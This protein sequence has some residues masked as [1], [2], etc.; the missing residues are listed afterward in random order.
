MERQ[1]VS[2]LTPCTRRRGCAFALVLALAL[3]PSTGVI[4]Q[5][6][7]PLV[8]AATRDPHR[9]ATDIGLDKSRKGPEVLAF[10]GIRPGWRVIDLMQG[11]GYYTRLFIAAAGPQGKAYAWSPDEFVASKKELYGD[12]L[13]AM[14][15]EY[16]DR[17]T[18]L[19]TPFE[20][21]APPANLD[22]VF[23]SQNY[24][25]LLVP[26]RAP[27]T[28]DRLNRQIFAALKPGGVYLIIDHV[29]KPGDITAPNR[30]HRIDPAVLRAQVEA[31]G[32]VFDGESDALRNPS[33]D[34]DKMVMDPS[35]RG[36]TDQL[37]YRFRKPAR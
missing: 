27:G 5:D 8:T 21:F 9:P 3:V 29:A 22:L 31:A 35:V 10:S 28:A 34:L 18:A 15:K 37:I 33:D 19:R 17:L 7:G 36:K 25:D 6:L 11:A 24:H 14:S 16:G 26:K 1:T 32:F 2:L 30:V 23:T 4:A 20:T 12:S 13:E